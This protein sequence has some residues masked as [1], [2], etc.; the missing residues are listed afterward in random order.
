VINAAT[1][2]PVSRALVQMQAAT[3][4]AQFAGADGTF[5][6]KKLARGRYNLTASKPGFFSEQQLSAWRNSFQDV[7]TEKDVVL[8][9]TPEGIIYGE[10]KNESGEPVEGVPVRAQRW[11]VDAAGRGATTNVSGRV[12]FPAGDANPARGQVSL[13]GD[14]TQSASAMLEKD[15][16]FSFAPV[17]EGPYKV[18]GNLP[19]SEEY[20]EGVYA[21]GAKASG[22]EITIAGAGDVQLNITMGRGVGQVTGVAKVDGK[23]TADVMVLL[24]PETG[25]NLEEDYRLDQSHSD[26]TFALGG[27]LPGKYSLLAIEDGWD[28]EWTNGTVLKPYLRKWQTLQI[29]ANDQKKVVVEVQH[30]V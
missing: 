10:V 15:G 25:Q 16:K 6:F 3:G 28:L 1:G 9:P 19:V 18:F 2:D 5:V 11:Q 27:I 22:R 20:V 23:P 12:I 24:V 13:V 17:Q 29:S 8:K 26:G 14:G 7:P 4:R 21:T 30:K